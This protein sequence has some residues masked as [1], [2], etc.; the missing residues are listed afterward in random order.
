[1]RHMHACHLL[2]LAALLLVVGSSGGEQR[3]G[4]EGSASSTG[5]GGAGGG[6]SS[7]SSSNNRRYHRVQHGQCTY[8]FILPEGEGNGGACREGK[9]GAVHNANALQR[10]APPLEPDLSTQKI[11]HLEHVM[12]NYTQWLQKVRDGA[13]VVR[14][15]FECVF[16]HCV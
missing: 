8:T 1:M 6:G 13:G 4:A 12:E 15:R 14:R 5:Q 7:G 9:T 11:Q 2:S 3:R 10:D 16:R